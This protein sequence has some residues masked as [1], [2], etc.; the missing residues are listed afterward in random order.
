MWRNK[1]E[2][3]MTNI[4]HTVKDGK[5][6]IVVK[7]KQDHGPSKSGKSTIVASTHGAASVADG[8]EVF[9]VSLNVY[10]KKV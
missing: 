8:G 3:T 4:E 10:K 5:L 9:E 7:L 1:G 2:R 6:T